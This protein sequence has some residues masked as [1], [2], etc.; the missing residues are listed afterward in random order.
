MTNQLNRR[1]FI[2]HS[3]LTGCALLMAAQM[4]PMHAF[5]NEDND[6][7]VPDPAKLEYCGYK[8]PD[9]CEF[10]KATKE[11]N[12]EL[13]KK[14]YE[15]WEIRQKHNAEFDPEKIFCW[16]CK[17]GEHPDGI[18]AINCSVRKCALEKGYEACI[19]CDN[20]AKCEKE[21]WTKFPKFH[22]KIQD[23]QTVYL[24]NKS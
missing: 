15:K 24:E 21:L 4:N 22:K 19:E 13:K 7:E 3:A 11:N 16:K 8:C 5:F 9:S 10:Y 23:M 14:A 18:V 6:T 20:L 1:K 2:K 12:T 17:A